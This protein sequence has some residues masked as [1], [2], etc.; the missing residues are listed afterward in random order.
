MA[1]YLALPLSLILASSTALAALP[2]VVTPM[3]TRDDCFQRLRAHEERR[4]Q[5]HGYQVQALVAAYGGE[6]ADGDFACSGRFEVRD[7]QGRPG[8]G[9][10][11]LYVLFRR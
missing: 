2:A 1:L 3:T 4:A 9:P 7:D 11:R 8:L 5:L 6:A 10:Q